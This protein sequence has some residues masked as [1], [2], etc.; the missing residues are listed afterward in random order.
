VK[1]RK[2][3]LTKFDADVMNHLSDEISKPRT[4]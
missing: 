1:A 4:K 2:S 3:E